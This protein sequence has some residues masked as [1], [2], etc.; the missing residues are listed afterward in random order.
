MQRPRA[1]APPVKELSRKSRFAELLISTNLL[2]CRGQISI[3]KETVSCLYFST[4]SGLAFDNAT[5][6]DIN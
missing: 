4:V 1:V 3:Q 6:V 2:Q 5:V